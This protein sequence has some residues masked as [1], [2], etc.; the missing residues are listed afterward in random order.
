[1][2]IYGVHP[3]VEAL[4]S[5]APQIE[6]I[7]ITRGK[8]GSRLQKIVELAKAQGVSIQ[9]ESDGVI[10]KKASTAHHQDVVRDITAASVAD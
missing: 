10:T 5:Q 1:M 6:G 7:W 4:R 8:S 3:V 9:F 2:I